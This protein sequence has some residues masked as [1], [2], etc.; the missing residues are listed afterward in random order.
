MRIFTLLAV[1]LSISGPI[2][3]QTNYYTVKFPDDKTY[4]GCNA[5]VP[6][7]Q[8]VITQYGCNINVGVSRY[9]QVFNTNAAGTC[10]KIL[11][12]WRLLY[13]CDYNANIPLT[14]VEN[15]ENT[16]VGPT[17]IGNSYN[18]GALEY[19]QI[20]KV[21]DTDPP[22]FANCPTE[23]VLFC[24]YSNN[25]PAQY[26]NPPH[27]DYCE[28]PVNLETDISDV[29]SG[30]DLTLSYR[31]YLDMDSNG[32]MET[33]VNSSSPTAWPVEKT[34]VGT[35]MHGKIQFPAGFQLPY[36]IHKIEWVAGDHCGNEAICK[37]EFEVRDCKNPTIVCINGLSVNI[38]QSGM[39]TL[40][41]SDF[42]NYAFDNCTPSDLI[43]IAIRKSGTGTGFPAGSTGVTF[44]CSELGT[45]LVEIWG[46][47]QHGN[48]DFC[49]TYVI[50]QDNMGSC[51]PTAS[52]SN[53]VLKTS[54][55]PMEGATVT[56]KTSNQT[57]AATAVT[58][59]QGQTSPMSLMPG[60]YT[61]TPSMSGTPAT[62]ISAWDALMIDLNNFSVEN[63]D[64]PWEFAAADVNND[65]LLTTEDVSA[66]VQVAIGATSTWPAVPAWQF[67]PAASALPAGNIEFPE[68]QQ[69]CVANF[70]TGNTDWVAVKSGDIDGSS[71]EQFTGDDLEERAGSLRQAKFT[72]YDRNYEPGETFEVTIFTP[73]LMGLSGFQL[74]L[75]YDP[76]ALEMI[77]S[78]PG[79]VP[80]QQLK[81]VAAAAHVRAGWVSATGYM[82]GGEAAYLNL[83]AFTVTF[84]SLK[85]GKLSNHLDLHKSAVKPEVY[86]SNHRTLQAR[87]RFVPALSQGDGQQL[88]AP[89]PNPVSGAEVTA[90]YL[91]PNATEARIS[92][93]D[94][95]GRQVSTQVV[96]GE[97]GYHEVV[98][99]VG[100]MRGAYVM[101]LIT[102][103]GMVSKVIEVLGN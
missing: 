24:D 81:P 47:D 73:E 89:V 13:W 87:L 56:A 35:Q 18:H 72:I 94:L 62:D 51:A 83:P 32:S 58:N 45:Q 88:F 48:A 15:P 9:D 97:A 27:Y 61:L 14:Y 103:D 52:I 33:F 80:G 100:T 71:A 92:F 59:A 76:T 54:G 38:M 1:L 91:L 102:G 10:F 41:A 65:G 68:T 22:V 93:A 101:Q 49:E 99:P 46:Q 2:Y 31:L 78:A 86:L 69:L 4:I 6:V 19:V 30:T 53:K 36:G 43:K 17:V 70:G 55:L 96:P 20:I 67:I 42:L 90:R 28:G 82:P 12:R 44:D 39:I 77:S 95:H 63:F 50:V 7:E 16:N 84:K 26:A 37:Y 79:L 66:V 60:C 85:A 11:R 64:Q 74:A 40:W 98:L 57:V 3:T 34:I 75:A 29:C 23:R 8:P 25:N 5:A 21:Y